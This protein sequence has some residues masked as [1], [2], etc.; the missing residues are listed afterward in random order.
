MKLSCVC[1]QRSLK[2]QLKT[3]FLCHHKYQLFHVLW[4]LAKN[5]LTMT[6]WWVLTIFLLTRS[7]ALPLSSNLILFSISSHANHSKT[8]TEKIQASNIWGQFWSLVVSG[9][10]GPSKTWQKTWP[11]PPPSP[12][13]GP[14]WPCPPCSP[15]P[16]G[17]G[18]PCPPGACVPAAVVTVQQSSSTKLSATRQSALLVAGLATMI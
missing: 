15:A 16:P 1:L 11:C 9:R 18:W 7:A 3:Q 10:E 14:G 17:P 12:C 6:F 5:T 2:F 4:R 8:P 13:P